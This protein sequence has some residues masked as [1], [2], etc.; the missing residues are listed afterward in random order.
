M[1]TS[2]PGAGVATRGCLV[3]G[4]TIVSAIAVLGFVPGAARAASTLVVPDDHPTIQAAVDAADAG[5]TVRVRSGSYS[6]Q[7]TI[8]K[9]LTL[10]GA[11][12]SSTTI[13][14]PAQLAPGD[15]DQAF[16]LGVTNGAMVTVS[17]LTVAGPSHGPCGTLNEGVLVA[18]DAMLTLRASAVTDIHDDPLGY[19]NRSGAGIRVGLPSF[20]AGP[21]VGH[22]SITDVTVSDYQ[23]EG[24][25]IGGAG[26]TANIAHNR[27]SGVGPSEATA[28]LGVAVLE[29]QATVIGNKVSANLCDSLTF[30]GPGCGPDPI[31]QFQSAGIIGFLAEEGTLFANNEVSDNDVG[32]YMYSSTGAVVSSNTAIDNRYFGLLL[33][34]GDY[35]ASANTISGG[36]TGVGVVADMVDTTAVLQRNRISGSSLAPVREL[37]C[38][39]FTARAV[40]RGR[41]PAGGA[42]AHDY[43]PA[44]RL[45]RIVSR[46]GWHSDSASA[47]RWR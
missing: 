8:V 39:G 27:I 22:A 2:H 1:G 35:A 32:L 9:E 23:F 17:G 45:R 6:E 7:V 42:R 14:A 15:F 24:I 46:A 29:A 43:H 21:S 25:A 4:A 33:Q 31:N 37:S 28:Q 19:C 30:G 16:L 40:V 3:R 13:R 44:E 26:S 5:D 41:G 20:T 18:D 36:Q 10:T 12:A 47:A 34:N 38:C 11:G